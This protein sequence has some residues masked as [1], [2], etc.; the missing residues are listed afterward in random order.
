[1]GRGGISF[2]AALMRR[3]PLDA[4]LPAD[5]ETIVLSSFL[6][7]T[8]LALCQAC[9]QFGCIHRWSIGPGIP[10]SSDILR[11]AANAPQ[12]VCCLRPSPRVGFEPSRG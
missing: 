3:C 9:T 4:I 8:P 2:A 10:A 11:R 12:K 6:T 1:M 7:L 5:F